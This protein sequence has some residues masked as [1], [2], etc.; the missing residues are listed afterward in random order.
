M[1][2]I[3]NLLDICCKHGDRD[4]LVF[5]G[6]TISYVQLHDAV[7]EAANG[8]SRHAAKG[9]RVAL[10]CENTAGFIITSLAIELV[11]AVRVPVN[12]K[13]TPVEIEKILADCEPVL[14]VTEASTRHLLGAEAGYRQ[15]D[16][17]A[18]PAAGGARPAVPLEPGDFCSITYTSGSTGNPKGVVLSHANWHCVYINMLLERDIREND[19]LAFIGPLT[20][21]GWSYL[22]AALMVGARSVIFKAGDTDSMVAYAAGHPVT[23]VTCV[24]TTLS[25]IV[26]VTAPDHPLVASLK[27]IGIG[28]APTSAA[29]LEKARALLGD[30]IVFNYGQTEAMMT[31]TYMDFRKEGDLPPEAE[32]IGRPYLFTSV[33]IVDKDGK[34]LPVGE[35]GEILVK[36]PHAMVGYWRQPELTEEVFD[37]GFIRTGDLGIES[38]PGL[39]KLIGRIKEMIISGGF[40][41]YPSE[42][43]A[44]VS[45]FPGIDEVA[46]IGAKSEEWGEKVV[47]FY[48]AEGD[49]AIDEAELRTHSKTRLGIK[50]PKDF[51]QLGAMPKSGTGKID[52]KA[53]RTL[54]EAGQ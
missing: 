26:A 15:M 27:W 1:L 21:A 25:R 41:I 11:G 6:K 39:F 2:P 19:T 49:A 5:G 37:D 47:C 20:H 22:Y 7:L 28:G 44:V 13:S 24:P 16:A 52:K 43:E 12:I 32:Y 9:D 42:V 40:N 54:Q 50:T 30:R 29:L 34:S 4:A 10:L 33:K 35:I 14:C 53:L 31:C 51:I 38:A 23:I 17:Q 36:G 48:S 18:L 8:L 46:V 45:V 3:L